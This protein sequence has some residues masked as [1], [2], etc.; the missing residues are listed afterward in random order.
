MT[1]EAVRE[2]SFIE[3]IG[4]GG[5]ASVWRA[6]DPKLGRDIA[7]KVFLPTETLIS[8]ALAHAKALARIEHPNVIPV[9]DIVRVYHPDGSGMIVDAVLMPLLTGGTLENALRGPM[10]S[11]K[12]AELIASA[13]VD[14]M[15]AIHDAG[16]AH[17]DLHEGNVIL[18]ETVGAKIIDILYRGTLATLPT[19][20]REQHFGRD[21]D[22]VRSLLGLVVG[23]TDVAPE[24]GY[25]YR[26]A[27]KP[28][29]TL[30]AFK[31]AFVAC[32]DAVSGGPVLSPSVRADVDHNTA[33]RLWGVLNSA[34]LRDWFEYRRTQ[35]QYDK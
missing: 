19:T 17:G 32:F 28:A 10:F 30:E 14:G 26:Q 8:D 35:R 16:L 24:A 3:H 34:W 33:R 2:L 6:S 4:D 21:L 18:D 5:F 15:K 23:H 13:I 25:F 9:Y 7:V 12:H 31:T 27:A 11:R 29:K 1:D 20:T 22:S